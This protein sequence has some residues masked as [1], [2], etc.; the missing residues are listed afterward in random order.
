MYEIESA[1]SCGHKYLD[2]S[3]ISHKHFINLLIYISY[4]ICGTFIRI[5]DGTLLTI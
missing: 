1:C 4:V 5:I 2:N 3:V